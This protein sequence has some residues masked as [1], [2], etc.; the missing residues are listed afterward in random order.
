MVV[1]F[2]VLFCHM[3]GRTE[4]NH[5]TNFIICGLCGIRTGNFINTKSD[6]ASCLSIFNRM[7]L[8]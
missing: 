8:L 4:K 2:E 1:K 3:H 7:A 5:E 6:P